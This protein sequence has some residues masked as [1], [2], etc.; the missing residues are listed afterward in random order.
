MDDDGAGVP[1]G[2]VTSSGSGQRVPW[3]CPQCGATSTRHGNG[4]VDECVGRHESARRAMC[5]GF[6]CECDD[7][8]T[9]ADHGEMFTKVCTNAVCHHCGWFGKFPVK[10][11][12]LQAW[13]R[14]AL[15]AGWMPPAPRAIEIAK[16][17]KAKGGAK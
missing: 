17:V 1:G 8:G 12:G 6:L 7:I 5:E 4:G 3:A 16:A 13:E 14:K 9:D 10:P 11:K 15:D 2:A